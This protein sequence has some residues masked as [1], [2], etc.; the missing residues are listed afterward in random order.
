M[1]LLEE[2]KQYRKSRTLESPQPEEL[3]EPHDPVPADELNETNEVNSADLLTTSDAQVSE[4]STCRGCA[5]IVPNGKTVCATCSH[6]DS[7]LVQN[8]VE[9]S[10]LA[11]EASLRGRALVALDRKRYPRL[12]LSKERRVGP[13]LIA[14]CPVLRAADPRTLKRIIELAERARTSTDDD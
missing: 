12:Q 2:L 10:E 1:S 4:S 6:A 3:K 7:P 11:Q 13:G 9:L 8:A 5:A 14:W